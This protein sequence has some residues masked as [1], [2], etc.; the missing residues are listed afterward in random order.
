MDKRFF[1]SNNNIKSEAMLA[2]SGRHQLFQ[3]QVGEISERPNNRMKWTRPVQTITQFT[4]KDRQLT[5]LTH[6]LGPAV[7]TNKCIAAY[8]IR[9]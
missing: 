9:K 1:I 5:S 3:S 8:S 2:G 7:L 4:S 6:I